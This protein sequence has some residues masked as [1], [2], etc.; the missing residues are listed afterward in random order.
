MQEIER[1]VR[2]R[3]NISTSVKGVKTFDCTVDM[4]GF[5]M[6]E[7]L[8]ESDKLVA[9]LELRYPITIDRERG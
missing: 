4:Q 9:A 5:T 6:E 7:V 8:A 2:H 1:T 3:I